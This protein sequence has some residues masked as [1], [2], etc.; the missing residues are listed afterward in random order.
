MKPDPITR[1]KDNLLAAAV[2][3]DPVLLSLSLKGFLNLLVHTLDKLS[4]VRTAL[5]NLHVRW[6][7]FEVQRNLWVKAIN[8]LKRGLVS[9]RMLGMVISKFNERQAT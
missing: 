7:W 1:L 5:T 9:D 2:E 8:N 3:L 4:P 6:Q